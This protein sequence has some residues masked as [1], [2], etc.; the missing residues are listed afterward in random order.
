MR[1]FPGMR[2]H[3]HHEQHGMMSRTE[4]GRQLFVMG[5]S[6]RPLSSKEVFTIEKNAIRKLRRALAKPK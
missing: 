6:D 5:L 2:V 3:L 1:L 4:I